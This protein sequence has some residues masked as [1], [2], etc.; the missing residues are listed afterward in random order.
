VAGRQ[1]AGAIINYFPNF[2]RKLDV[3]DVLGD[4]VEP[5]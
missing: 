5:A 2:I 4:I 3:L 1:A